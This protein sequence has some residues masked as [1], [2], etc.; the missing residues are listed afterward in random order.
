MADGATAFERL[1]ADDTLPRAVREYQVPLQAELLRAGAQWEE[2]LCVL[3]EMANH[4]K[5]F[6]SAA[7]A[8]GWYRAPYHP[9]L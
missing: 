8:L 4:R 1:P 5:S 3:R 2:S 7:D 6:P 9:S